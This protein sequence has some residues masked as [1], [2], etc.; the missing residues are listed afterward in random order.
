MALMQTLPCGQNRTGAV[1]FDTT[2]FQSPI[3]A[4]MLGTE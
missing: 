4:G 2:A 3:D 1:A